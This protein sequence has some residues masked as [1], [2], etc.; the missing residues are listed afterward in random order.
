MAK[1]LWKIVPDSIVKG[2]SIGHLVCEVESLTPKYKQ[3]PRALKL[4]DRNKR[5]CY[6]HVI[7]MENKL[8]RLL[9]DSEEVHHKNENPADNR[10]SNLEL[11]SKADHAQGHSFKKKFWKKSPRNKPG[12]E[13]ACRVAGQFLSRAT[14]SLPL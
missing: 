2:D 12:R 13:A 9:L 6:V 1:P 4:P 14:I 5:Y 11:A 10:L 3:H 7:K 8:G